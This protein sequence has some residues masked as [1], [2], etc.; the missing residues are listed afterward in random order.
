[1]K[2][3][4][5]KSAQ[6]YSM[7]G[8]IHRSFTLIELLVVIAIIAILAGMLLPALNSAREK[9]RS[10]SCINN[11]KQHGIVFFL[12]AENNTDHFYPAGDFWKRVWNNPPDSTAY[13]GEHS[14]KMNYCPSGKTPDFVGNAPGYG[15]N[16]RSICNGG[17]RIPKVR[18]V[19]EPAGMYLVMDRYQDGATAA[20]RSATS[21]KT[22]GSLE[23]T[24]SYAHPGAP[25][26]KRC[27]IV[28]VDG[29][30]ENQLVVNPFHAYGVGNPGHVRRPDGLGIC[31]WTYSNGQ[32][33]H[34][35]E[36]KCP[37]AR[38]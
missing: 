18:M 10:A 25:H 5:N 31:G 30:V 6:P 35:R 7:T 26:S 29:H 20:E 15:F 36:Y 12:Y 34:G 24:G 11:L 22:Y 32:E 19:V 37:W 17:W 27:N 14:W 21:F 4:Q 1:M 16:G 13:S 23:E 33:S 9:G 3:V 38:F 8:V 2:K 28:F